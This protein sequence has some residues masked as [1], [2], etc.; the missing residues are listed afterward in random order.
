MKVPGKWSDR[1]DVSGGTVVEP[2]LSVRGGPAATEG[3]AV[4]FTVRAFPAPVEGESLTVG[5]TV[6]QQGDFV[7]A[8]DLGRKSVTIDHLG[9]ARVTIPTIDDEVDEAN[10]A[11]TLTLN[12]GVGYTL[13]SARSAS[14]RVLDDEISEVNFLGN[15]PD[16]PVGEN[17]GRHNVAV[18]ISPAPAASLTID[19]TVDSSSTAVAGEDFRIDGLTGNSGSVTARA[20]QN[21]VNIPVQLVNDRVSEGDETIVLTLE[22]G[23]DYD[24]L[25]PITYTLT[26]EDDDGTGVAFDREKGSV[27]EAGG[28]RRVTINLNP[29]PTADTSINYSVGGQARA[30]EDYTIAG[31]TGNAGSALAPAGFGSVDIEVQ[32]LDD[33]DNEGD[34]ELT[35]TLLSS[36]DYNTLGG[37]RKHTLTI[38]D[39]DRPRASFASGGSSHGEDEAGPHDVTVNISPAPSTDL[40]LRYGV[41]GTA[42]RG[43]DYTMDNYGAVTVP[44]GATSVVIPVTINEDGNSER[45]ETVKLTLRAGSN[46]AVSSAPHILTIRDNDQPGIAFSA[47]DASVGESAR[48]YRAVIDVEPRPHEDLTINYS[49]ASASTADSP[50]DYTIA[51]LTVSNSG[52]VTARR[53]AGPAGSRSPSPSRTTGTAKAPRR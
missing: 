19:Y 34:E 36:A 49:I 4:T 13:S 46:Y 50:A 33:D 6:T 41:N 9:E 2:Q 14:V 18:A 25:S 48:T 42:T 37:I 24:L 28:T 39:N 26:I 29:P 43:R 12:N 8:G 52:T 47:A 23:A 5:Y 22:D 51:G 40:T 3:G 35:L 38:L 10:G 16:D 53:G 45:N 27:G 44:A 32:V 21:R 31:L 15:Q 7:A 17:S 1:V 11:V 30:G 20:G